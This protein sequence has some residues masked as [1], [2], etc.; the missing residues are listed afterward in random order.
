MSAQTPA[1]LPER[2]VKNADLVLFIPRDTLFDQ[3]CQEIAGHRLKGGGRQ[4]HRHPP[5]RK[6]ATCARRPSGRPPLSE[7]AGGALL[8][9]GD[10][11]ARGR[12]P[13]T[14]ALAAARP[15]F[16]NCGFKNCGFQCV[17]ISNEWP[18][19]RLG[20]SMAFPSCVSGW[21]EPLVQW[22]KGVNRRLQPGWG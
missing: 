15:G 20:P 16:L 9:K 12:Q 10:C 19:L 1:P 3:G 2:F 4:L 14:A 22:G 21:H 11:G 13:G 6:H 17:C 8:R 7:G 18:S 5:S